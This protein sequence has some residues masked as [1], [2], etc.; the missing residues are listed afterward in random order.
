MIDRYSSRSIHHIR[1]ARVQRTFA[2][3]SS[4]STC[5]HRSSQPTRTQARSHCT[6][7][8]SASLHRHHR[9]EPLEYVD[10][11]H[12]TAESRLMRYRARVAVALGHEHWQDGRRCSGFVRSTFGDRDAHTLE[13]S[14]DAS[15]F[16]VGTHTQAPRTT[17]LDR[18]GSRRVACD[19][20]AVWKRHCRC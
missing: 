20:R 16:E 9:S 14:A 7:P 17:V 10:T 13:A 5:I 1:S 15:E 12:S 11:Q 19:Q 2:S 18:A 3:C 4:S 6:T 8:S